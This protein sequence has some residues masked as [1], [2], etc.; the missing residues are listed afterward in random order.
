ME[1]EGGNDKQQSGQVQPALILW[2]IPLL[3]L[4]FLVLLLLRPT[5]WRFALWIPYGVL[6][7][8]GIVTWNRTRQRI[9][10]EE[11]QSEQVH[12]AP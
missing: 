11:S 1:E 4:T 10:R 7:P 5:P 9:R 8:L 3:L 12:P 2:I 6:M